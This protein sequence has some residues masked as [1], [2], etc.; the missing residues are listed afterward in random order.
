MASDCGLGLRAGW[1]APGWGGLEPVCAGPY[2]APES[3]GSN[4]VPA[5]ERPT[6]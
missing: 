4:R 3:R 1:Q 6:G 5:L 2:V